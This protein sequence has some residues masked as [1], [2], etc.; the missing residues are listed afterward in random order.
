MKRYTFQLIINEGNDEFWEE[1]LAD[2]KSGADAVR[3]MV[4]DALWSVGF[5]VS[6]PDGTLVLIKYEDD[7]HAD[8]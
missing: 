3:E 7:L 2:G 5:D 6:G 1:T 4:S 8:I